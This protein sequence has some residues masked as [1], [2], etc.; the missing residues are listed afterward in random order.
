MAAVH[1]VV[2]LQ[3]SND[4]LNGLSAFEKLL[5]F[6]RQ[7]FELA[8]V[9]DVNAQVVLVYATVAQVDA[10]GFRLRAGRLH[11]DAGL[12]HLFVQCVPVIRVTRKDPGADDE[13][14][15]QLGG[16]AHLHTKL[17]GVTAFAFG[18]AFD[19]W[20]VPAVQ[21]GLF[22]FCFVAGQAGTPCVG[23]TGTGNHLGGTKHI[24]VFDLLACAHLMGESVSQGCFDLVPG[25]AVGQDGQWM[26]QVDHLIEAVTEKIGARGHVRSRNSQKTGSIEYLFGSIGYSKT[27]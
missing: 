25:H 6:I 9:F 14:A 4:G 11:Q 18:D 17:V 22:V 23:D 21:L 7:A 10:S 12:L 24:H 19:F 5:F 3:V 20:R 27:P 2:C 26:T 1:P 8:P 13:G 15:F 16:N